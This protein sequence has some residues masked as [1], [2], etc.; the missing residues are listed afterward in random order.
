MGIKITE[1][2]H[3][4]KEKPLELLLFKARIIKKLERDRK[5][6]PTECCTEDGRA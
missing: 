2:I 6:Q 3:D 4:N 1:S 5:K